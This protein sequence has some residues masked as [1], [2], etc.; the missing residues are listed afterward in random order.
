MVAPEILDDEDGPRIVEGDGGAAEDPAAA[1]RRRRTE[2]QREKRMRERKCGKCGKWA[3]AGLEKWGSD[4]D[5][6]PQDLPICVGCRARIRVDWQ[7]LND[8]GFSCPRDLERPCENCLRQAPAEIPRPRTPSDTP[9][10]K[11]YFRRMGA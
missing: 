8:I 1:D 5:K 2:K 4:K 9:P 10:P 11:A 3:D 6:S 7:N